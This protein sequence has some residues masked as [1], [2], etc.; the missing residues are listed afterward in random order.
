M[1]GFY[2]PSSKQIEDGQLHDLNFVV[3]NFESRA[4]SGNN[5]AR[6]IVLFE[7]DQS[8]I[9]TYV[10]DKIKNFWSNLFERKGGSPDN[11]KLRMNAWSAETVYSDIVITSIF[12][13]MTFLRETRS[14]FFPIQ[15]WVHGNERQSRRPN[16]LALSRQVQEVPFPSSVRFQSVL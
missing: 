7:S 2:F 3:T 4:V 5:S 15:D 11:L 16:D 9:Q 10:N 14:E 13:S 6:S 12:R 8:G 1:Y